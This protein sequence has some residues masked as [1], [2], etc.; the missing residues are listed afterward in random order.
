MSNEVVAYPKPPGRGS[1]AAR[2]VG[3]FV[4][5]VVGVLA[6]LAVD[7][8]REVRVERARETAYYR[9]LAVDLERDLAEYDIAL[10]MTARSIAAANQVLSVVRGEE[11][12][13]VVGPLGQ[14]VR[15]ASW[16][17]YPDWSMGTIEELI[18]SGSVRLIRDRDIKSAM[19]RYREDV[20]EWR[21]RLQGPEFR[22]FLE[23]RRATR[24][25]LPRGI[26]PEEDVGLPPVARMALARRL[27]GDEDLRLMIR[28]MLGEWKTLTAV[29]E[30]Q[31][32]RALELKALV[33]ARVAVSGP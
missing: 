20:N 16:V 10:A 22:T 32:D 7:E 23:Y 6:A 31:R 4:V 5:I 21:P 29:L 1:Y 2:L 3:E 33:D 15:W 9:A 30:G 17:N 24:G 12:N 8:W 28:G 14:A 26:G 25:Y 11:P 13:E 19:L 18:S 27:E